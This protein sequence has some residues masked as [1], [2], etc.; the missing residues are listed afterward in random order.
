MKGTITKRDRNGFGGNIMGNDGVLYFYHY[1]D[2]KPKDNKFK[3]GRKVEF[4]VIDEGKPHLK[5]INIYL[6]KEEAEAKLKEIQEKE[7]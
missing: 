2:C 1:S 5:A 3:K 4:D 7:N 6:L